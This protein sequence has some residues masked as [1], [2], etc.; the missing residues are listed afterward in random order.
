MDYGLG[1]DY[2]TLA[3]SVE[4]NRWLHICAYISPRQV[5][6]IYIDGR[7]MSGINNSAGYSVR[8][9]MN[10]SDFM[11]FWDYQL[12]IGN[13]RGG[14]FNLPAT[15][16]RIALPRI[17]QTIPTDEQIKFTYDQE[18][19]WFQAGDGAT[20][21]PTS[22]AYAI[23]GGGTAFSEIDYDIHRNEY[24]LVGDNGVEVRKGVSR[25]T[26][27]SAGNSYDV[28]AIHDGKV[29]YGT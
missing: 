20:G 17:S 27:L 3:N 19:P 8:N 10:R 13:I 22:K 1:G 25:I 26:S 18:K 28:A 7:L 11:S 6:T 4:K 12:V 16:L 23:A 9:R 14:H 29:V 5:P 24:V 21:Y 2:A 15:N